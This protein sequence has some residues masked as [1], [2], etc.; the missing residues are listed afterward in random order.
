MA[1]AAGEPPPGATRAYLSNPRTPPHSPFAQFQAH[2]PPRALAALPPSWSTGRRTIAAA[3]A[4][5]SSVKPLKPFLS[6]PFRVCE[7]T[8][9]S[10]G[11]RRVPSAQSARRRRHPS[12]LA[13]GV[14]LRRR[15]LFHRFL[16]H[17][18]SYAL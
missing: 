13:A 7:L 18:S 15:R 9:A 5:L 6:L 4:P 14:D 8:R 10:I 1:M 16:A 17:R 12:E 2:T 3:R 11:N